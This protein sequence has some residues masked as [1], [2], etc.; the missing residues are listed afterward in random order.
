MSSATRRL[1]RTDWSVCANRTTFRRRCH[2]GMSG[3][4][5]CCSSALKSKELKGSPCFVLRRSQ[6]E[7]FAH[8]I[9]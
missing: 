6:F 4:R 8:G 3:A 5:T 1:V 7:R 9:V 2:S